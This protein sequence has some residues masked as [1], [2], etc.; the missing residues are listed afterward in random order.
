MS[1]V[2]IH[3]H[4]I[5]SLT[6]SSDFFMLQSEYLVSLFWSLFNPLYEKRF[7]YSNSPPLPQG[8]WTSRYDDEGECSHG[9]ITARQTGGGRVMRLQHIITLLLCLQT[10][11]GAKENAGGHP[12]NRESLH[13]VHGER[14]SWHCCHG[15][16][17]GWKV[18]RATLIVDSCWLYNNLM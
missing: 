16:G 15:S 14:D 2:I 7:S 18:N 17:P 4:L 13:D 6:R 12:A 5:V 8:Y 9:E 3:C 10:A 11:T 1:R